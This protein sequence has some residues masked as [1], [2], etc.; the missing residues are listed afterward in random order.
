M[1]LLSREPDTTDRR[2]TGARQ[3]GTGRALTLAGRAGRT[4]PGERIWLLAKLPEQVRVRN[5]RL[6][7]LRFGSGVRLKSRSGTW[8]WKW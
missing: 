8:P 7:S 2:S 1:G 5:S 3:A 4:R 6:D